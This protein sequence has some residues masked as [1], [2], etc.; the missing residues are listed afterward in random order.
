MKLVEEIFKKSIS[1]LRLPFYAVR[2]TYLL[3]Y[4]TPLHNNRYGIPLKYS[5]VTLSAPLLD[6]IF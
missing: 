4:C 3:A 5:I 2:H 1:W 6:K